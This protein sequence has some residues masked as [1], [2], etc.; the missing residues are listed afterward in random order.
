MREMT[1]STL[2]AGLALSLFGLQ[3]MTEA[4]RGRRPGETGPTPDDIDALTRAMVDQTDGALRETFQVCDK[5]QR[6]L[7]DLAFGFLDRTPL[8]PGGAMG[9]QDPG[10]Q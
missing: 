8:R 7:V 10:A 6:G 3:A 1:K 5:V 2:G 9:T 4:L